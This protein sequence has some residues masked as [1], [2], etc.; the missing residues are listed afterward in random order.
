MQGHGYYLEWLYNHVQEL[1]KEL[2]VKSTSFWDAWQKS[3]ECLIVGKVC[4]CIMH[5]L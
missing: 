5:T 2:T 1:Q 3:Q 4:A